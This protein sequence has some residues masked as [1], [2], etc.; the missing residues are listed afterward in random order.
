MMQ[1]MLRRG[2]Y[3]NFSKISGYR[4]NWA[5]SEALPLTACCPKS[6]FQTCNFAWPQKGMTYLGITFPPRL[7]DFVKCNFEPLLANLRIDIERWA[8]LFLSLWGKVNVI[9][10]TCAPKFNYLLQA[11]PVKIP[12]TYFKQFDSICNIFLWNKKRPKLKLRTLQR[13]VDRGGLGVPNLQLYHL[14]FSLRHLAHWFLPPERAPPWFTLESDLCNPLSPAYLVTA[15]L[16]PEV[17]KHPVISHL[18]WVWRKVAQSAKINPYLHSHAGIWLNPKL[19]IDKVPFLWTLWYQKGIKG[20]GD[21]YDK[22]ILR[23]FENIK[24]TYDIPQN[25]FWRYLQLRHL[26]TKTFGSTSQAPTT[27]DIWC[28]I[29][30]ISGKAHAASAYYSM[31]LQ[32]SERDL[33][34][35]RSRWEVELHSDISKE[36]M[37]PHH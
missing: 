1:C 7:S 25:Q 29:V 30:K 26:L 14:A 2:N 21:L 24:Q 32:D 16:P 19:F 17:N 23:S 31:M 28:H 11:S 18:Q 15:Q 34:A 36:K 20:L 22:G 27:A 5:K 13:S 9:K 35:L 6:L 8:P 4:V 12:Q 3:D 37:E 33:S 10:M